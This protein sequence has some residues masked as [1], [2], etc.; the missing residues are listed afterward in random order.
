MTRDRTSQV[1]VPGSSP[2]PVTLT[3][4][5]WLAAA[6]VAVGSAALGR[7]TLARQATPVASP[8]AA[9]RDW[10]NEYWVGTW[11]A[12]PNIPGPGF[13]EF[14]PSQI[15]E[16]ADQTLRQV[17]RTSIGGDQV[18]VRLSNLFGEVSVVIGAAH[19][20]LRDGDARIDP[21]TDRELTFS[22]NPTVAIPP[23]ALVLSD[24]VDLAIDPLSELAVSLYFPEPTTGTTVHGFAFQ[25]NYISSQG[26]FTAEAE[27]PVESNP[28]TWVFLTG[29]DVTAPRGSGAVDALGDSLT[30][31]TLSTPDA[32]R[33][34][35]DLLAN[36]LI[37]EGQPL[38]VLNQG[39][40][41]NRLLGNGAGDFIFAGPSALA[42]L[43]R[44]V[45]A[46]AGVTHLIVFE[47]INDIGLS[48]MG[49]EG[50]T[51]VTADQLI[52]ALCQIAERA[53]EVDLAV[54]GATITPFE[55]AMYFTPKGETTRQEI[56]NWIRTGDALDAVLDFDAVVRDPDNPSAILPAYDAGDALHFNDA[57]FQAIADSIDL[58]L[59]AESGDR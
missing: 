32:N 59:F 37:A 29:V 38:G 4:R 12:A 9:G 16:F 14:M 43:E 8:V 33:R 44:D 2:A 27:M 45:L 41:G 35:P 21:A 24:P 54:F 19:V 6:S 13:E 1:P 30:D 22:G 36:R 39:I 26:D 23:G 25:T 53:H 48:A 55:G 52:F 11:A 46:Q 49:G 15:F 47:G 20:A 50:A 57:G 7:G 10:L 42:R 28:Q 51:P 56:N 17:V 18:R 3:R 40:G 34:W 5:R 31:G 58:A